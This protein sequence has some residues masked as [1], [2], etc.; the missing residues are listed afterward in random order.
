MAT[1]K[2]ILTTLKRTEELALASGLIDPLDVLVM[3]EPEGAQYGSTSWGVAV[4][5]HGSDSMERNTLT[6]LPDSGRNIGNTKREAQ[7]TL[8]TVNG[9]MLAMIH[10][11]SMK[12]LGY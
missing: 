10:N 7:E 3:L 2:D 9:T 4:V 1:K 8:R 11:S 12:R 5:R 6:F